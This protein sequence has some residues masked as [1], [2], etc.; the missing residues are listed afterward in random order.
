VFELRGAI[1]SIAE[2]EVGKRDGVEEEEVEWRKIKRSRW[3]RGLE[4][5]RR[6]RMKKERW[7]QMIGRF[8]A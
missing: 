6:K 4:L 5:R 2:V 1:E 3:R 7:L 8:G